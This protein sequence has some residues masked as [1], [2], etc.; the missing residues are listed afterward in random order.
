MI[1]EIDTI[2]ETA[3]T[4]ATTTAQGIDTTIG[5]AMTDH[6]VA[7]AEDSGALEEPSLDWF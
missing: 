4:V 1:V 5:A 7:E 6:E 3:M 2:A